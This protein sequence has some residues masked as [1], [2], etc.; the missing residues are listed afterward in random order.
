[1]SIKINIINRLG[2]F[3]ILIFSLLNYFLILFPFYFYPHDE[4]TYNSSLTLYC[5]STFLLTWV[6]FSIIFLIKAKVLMEVLFVFGIATSLPSLYV[7]CLFLTPDSSNIYK[8]THQSLNNNL[9]LNFL[10]IL[11]SIISIIIYFIILFLV[12]KKDI[13]LNGLETKKGKK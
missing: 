8:W 4:D 3:L 5:C 13:F 9:M 12:Y 1:M 11:F 10:Q 2:L 6:I 7:D